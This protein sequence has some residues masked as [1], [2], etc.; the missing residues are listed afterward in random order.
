M[1]VA[2]SATTFTHK[3]APAL[4]ALAVG[5]PTA[6][7]AIALWDPSTNGGPPLCPFRGL[8][9]VACP[10]CG[11]TR[12]AGAFFR[13]RWGEAVEIHPLIVLVVAQL[14]LLWA[15]A[16]YVRHRGLAQSPQR[17]ALP[18]LG[19]NAAL[20]IAV[21]LVRLATGSLDTSA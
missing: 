1:V 6:A 21:W 20:F 7:V 5:L 4:T 17:W 9:G 10:G 14:T 18:L 11:L 3:R 13:G 19:L 2:V 8:T 16:V 12:A 15:F